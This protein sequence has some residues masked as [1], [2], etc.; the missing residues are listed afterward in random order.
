MG[1]RTVRVTAP[2]R[3]HLGMLSFGN[4]GSPQ[5]GGAGVMIQ[6]P[7]VSLRITPGREASGCRVQ[8]CHA[9]RVREFVRRWQRYYRRDQTELDLELSVLCAPREHVGLGLGTQLGLSV[10][11]GLHAYFEQPRPAPLELAASVGRGERSAVG[12]HGFHRGGLIVEQRRGPCDQLGC[13]QR[14]VALPEAWR[15]VLVCPRQHTGLAG[16]AER[17]AFRRL[18]PVPTGVTRR[19]EAELFDRLVP[20]ARAGHFAEFSDGVYRYGKLAGDCFAQVQGGPFA[21]ADL[22][23]L[24]RQ[25]R[26]MGI[27]GVGQSSWGPTLFAWVP[28]DA[29]ARSLASSL[30][31]QKDEEE[32]DIEITAVDNQGVRVQAHVATL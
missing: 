3:L 30:R 21:G 4:P 20:A 24:V 19:L 25:I 12:T 5:F 2:S 10:A 11:A 7:G 17:A 1:E 23:R 9:Q 6:R 14:R 26:A 15:A 22:A 31:R 27:E 16:P 13:L 8:G 32:V 28:D 18:P 29:T